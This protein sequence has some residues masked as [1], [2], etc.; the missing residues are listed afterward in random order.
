MTKFVAAG[1]RAVA[2][3]L[4]AGLGQVIA[5]PLLDVDVSLLKVAAATGAGAV[6]NLIYRWSEAVVGERRG[7]G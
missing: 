4:F 5:Y 7:N 6:V 1:R 2:T 3:F